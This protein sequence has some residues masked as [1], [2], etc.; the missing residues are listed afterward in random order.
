MAVIGA[1]CVSVNKE[2]C[3]NA[4]MPGKRPAPMFVRTVFCAGRIPLSEY[5]NFTLVGCRICA[6]FCRSMRFASIR[7]TRI[8]HALPVDLLDH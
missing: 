2:F 6:E 3:I 1:F 5:Q 8:H 7:R 4:Q